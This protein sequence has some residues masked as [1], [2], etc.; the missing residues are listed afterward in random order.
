MKELKLSEI[1]HLYITQKTIIT[2]LHS[3]IVRLCK[4]CSNIQHKLFN[5][6]KGKGE[7][8]SKTVI[9]LPVVSMYKTILTGICGQQK[10]SC[11]MSV[12][13]GPPVI[14]IFPIFNIPSVVTIVLTT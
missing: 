1:S 5:H 6:L 10:L 12:V 11:R 3:E 9:F 4:I 2:G 14:W 7:V 13:H 8:T